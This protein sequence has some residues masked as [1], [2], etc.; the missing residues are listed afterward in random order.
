[1]SKPINNLALR[2]KSPGSAPAAE[3]TRRLTDR[4][5]TELAEAR[6]YR[7][8]LEDALSLAYEAREELD[9]AQRRIAILE[10]Q[11]RTD[12]TTG[13]LNL[14]GFEVALQAALARVKRYGEKGVLVMIDLDGFTAVNEGHGQQAG[15]LILATVGTVLSRHTRMVDS[16]ARIGSDEF[17]VILAG[18]DIEGA[19]SRVSILD[20]ILNWTTVPWNGARI[21]VRATF[22]SVP[23]GPKDEAE[24]LLAVADRAIRDGNRAGSGAGLQA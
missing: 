10:H 3:L 9:A 8:M 19:K 5:P 15:D 1:M 23:F 21:P 24:G 16:V 11:S 6:N 17:A 18:A 14:R 4:L 20:R 12:P 7:R 2:P 22:H 13:L